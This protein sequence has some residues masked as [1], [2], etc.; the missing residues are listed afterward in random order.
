MFLI[1]LLFYNL[2]E[3]KGGSEGRAIRELDP[4][5]PKKVSNF[6]DL[7]ENFY[8]GKTVY[9]YNLGFYAIYFIIVTLQCNRAV[10]LCLSFFGK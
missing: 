1:S 9:F 2:I 8:S 6:E 10:F 7:S 5:I 4:K 3:F